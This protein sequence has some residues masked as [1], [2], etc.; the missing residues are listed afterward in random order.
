M[1]A[2]LP[3]TNLCPRTREKPE[4]NRA[5]PLY[6]FQRTTSKPPRTKPREIK[7]ALAAAMSGDSGNTF[8]VRT[9]AL[10]WPSQTVYKN[11][12]ETFEGQPKTLARVT[13]WN[14]D[15]SFDMH[16]VR[17][18]YSMRAPLRMDESPLVAE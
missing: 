10:L 1:L 13:N 2:T 12:V 15:H 16:T 7:S 5:S 9:P 8:H 18:K 6:P 3:F 11:A 4:A 14:H 17:A